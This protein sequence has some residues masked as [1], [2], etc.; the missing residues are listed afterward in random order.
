MTIGGRLLGLFDIKL[1]QIA[2]NMN[3]NK[4]GTTRFFFIESGL[5]HSNPISFWLLL[6]WHYCFGLLILSL[7]LLFGKKVRSTNSYSSR[8]PWNYLCGCLFQCS[9]SFL[10]TRL[11]FSYY[12]PSNRRQLF[13]KVKVSIGLFLRNLPMR[14]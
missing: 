4:E 2:A 6:Y 8:T 10:V 14:P 5:P 3:I 11:V 1:V 9:C 12:V 13:M 7:M